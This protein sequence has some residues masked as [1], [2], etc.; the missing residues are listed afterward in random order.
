MKKIKVKQEPDTISVNTNVR[1]ITNDGRWLTLVE[2]RTDERSL[3]VYSRMSDVVTQT[4]VDDEDNWNQFT[5]V[6]LKK[7]IELLK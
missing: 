7:M 3:D 2:P 6:E 4:S 5:L 1:V